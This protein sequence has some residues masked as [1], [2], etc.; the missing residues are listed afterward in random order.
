MTY[1]SLLLGFLIASLLGA[2]FHLWRG[3]SF[4]RLLLY[5]VL[6]WIG[7]WAGHFLAGYME[8]TYDRVGPLHAG[9][10]AIAS[11]LLLMVGH[12]LS[13]IEVERY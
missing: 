10:G 2:A 7:F 4:G 9:T 13:K 1:P 3:G 12:W 6:G 11:L 8:W 5:L